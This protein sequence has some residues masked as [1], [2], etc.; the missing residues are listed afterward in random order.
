[1]Y[2]FLVDDVVTEMVPLP[3]AP[4]G[5]ASTRTSPV[6]Y[7]PAAT[8]VCWLVVGV[9]VVPACVS[10]CSVALPDTETVPAVPPLT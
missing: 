6:V 10:S 8:A 1:M 2:L 9:I 4:A 5:M 7:F 3:R